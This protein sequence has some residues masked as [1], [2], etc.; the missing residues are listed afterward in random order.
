MEYL[1]TLPIKKTVSLLKRFPEVASITASQRHQSGWIVYATN[2]SSDNFTKLATLSGCELQITEVWQVIHYDV[3][4][5]QGKLTPSLIEALEKLKLDYASI[6]DIPNLMLPGVAVFDM[7]S[8]M[9]NMEC[10]D[11]IAKLAGVG[12]EVAQVTELAMQGELDFEQSLRQRVAKLAGADESILAQVKESLPFMPDLKETIEC[13]QAFDWKVAVASGGFTYFSEH[14]KQI[15][16]LDHAYS[17]QLEIKQGKLTGKV[18]GEVVSAETKAQVL[19]QLVVDYGVA[20]ENTI[21]VGDGA[22]DLVMMESAG[23]GIAFHAKPKVQQ[24]AQVAINQAGLGGI[25][26]VLTAQLAKQQRIPTSTDS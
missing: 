16:K 14:L 24:Q 17:N 8:T 13:L 1:A 2:L 19:Q 5:M 9:I 7:D 20:L 6:E 3:A 18:V 23:L 11:E 25:L 21:A 12:D 4:L 26:C 22:N 10:I 15:L